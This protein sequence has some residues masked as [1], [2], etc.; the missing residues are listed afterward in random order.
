MDATPGPASRHHG[1][2][3]ARVTVVAAV[4]VRASR[5]VRARPERRNLTLTHD[6]GPDRAQAGDTVGRMLLSLL[7]GEYSH[8]NRVPSSDVPSGQTREES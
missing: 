7:S 3:D 6:G 4:V 8:A 1:A 5:S 2:G